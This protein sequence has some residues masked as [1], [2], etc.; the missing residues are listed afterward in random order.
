MNIFN[1]VLRVP[2]NRLLIKLNIFIL[3]PTVSAFRAG[4]DDCVASDSYSVGRWFEFW[5]GTDNSPSC[6]RHC[7]QIAYCVS[8]AWKNWSQIV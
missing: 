4:V 7:L 3:F 1:F 2:T 8:A 5:V 6:F